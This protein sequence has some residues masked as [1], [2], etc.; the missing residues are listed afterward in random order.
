LEGQVMRA[1]RRGAIP[2][3]GVLTLVCVLAATLLACGPKRDPIETLLLELE[4]GAEARQASVIEGALAPEFKG[5]DGTPRADVAQML[6]RYFVAYETVNL[7]VYDVVIERQSEG[8]ARVAFR[9]DFNGRPLQL[10]GLAAMLP[11]AAMYRFDLGL[12]L[13][14]QRWLIA[15]ADWE[16]VLPPR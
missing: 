7:E 13:E 8:A 4:R 6:R 16:E 11:P 3:D 12:R 9:V 5:R 2:K 10:G 1:Q 15:T 14:G